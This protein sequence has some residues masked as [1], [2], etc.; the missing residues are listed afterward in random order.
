MADVLI[1]GAGFFGSVIAERLA[2]EDGINV[3]IIDKRPHVGGNCFSFRDPA[4][5]VECHQYGSHI[6]HTSNQRVWDYLQHFTRFNGYRH[7]VHAKYRDKVYSLPI[8]LATINAFY[9]CTL[10]PKD[11][12]AFIQK[13]VELSRVE[14]PDNLEDKAIS[15]IGRPLYEAFIKGYTIKQWETDPRLLPAEIIT[16]LPVRHNY[17]SF[18][19][20]DIYEGI[21]WDGYTRIFER[22]L[23]HALIEVQLNTDYFALDARAQAY[24]L[25][26]YS[27]PIDQ[28]FNYCAGRLDWRAIRFDIRRHAEPD[29]QGCSVM[30]YADPEI[31]FTRIHEFQHFHPER[32]DV[33][34]TITYT[35]YSRM[36]RLDDDLSYPVNTPRNMRLL[37]E[38][39][40][41]VRQEKRVV[42]GGRLG[43][44]RYLDMD[45]TILAALECYEMEIR[46]RLSKRPQ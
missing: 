16:R 13:E 6:F 23:D 44:Y 2:V 18:Y 19:F 1:V 25:I 28:Y 41:L 20:N 17:N 5:G 39:H 43:S 30:N 10:A 3:K 12:A 38:Y 8:N 34:Q 36:A 24:D 11:V 46:P 42:F 4:T 15:L 27:G 37:K 32:K 22:M 14:H 45:D 21:P 40:H 26:V 35:E 29:Y 9:G 31:P 33:S 7:V